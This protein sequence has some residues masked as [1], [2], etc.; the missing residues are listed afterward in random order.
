MLKPWS[1]KEIW[2]L[3]TLQNCLIGGQTCLS[4][5]D[6]SSLI[7]AKKMIINQYYIIW[8]SYGGGQKNPG[9]LGWV[10]G[11]RMWCVIWLCSDNTHYITITFL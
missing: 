3:T 4:T 2:M 6:K 1:H 10:P 9:G 5:C 11:L 8:K 7:I